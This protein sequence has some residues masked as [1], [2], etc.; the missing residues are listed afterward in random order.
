M[1]SLNSKLYYDS[2]YNELIGRGNVGA[3]GNLGG[4]GF[5]SIY[6]D[7]SLGLIETVDFAFG[8][9]IDFKVGLN[10]RND[11]H[12]ARDPQKT[13]YDDTKL[14]DFTTSIFAE[15]AQRINSWFR[16]AL[17]GSYDRNDILKAIDS[18]TKTEKVK[19]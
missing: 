2:F 15:Y 9:N 1:V 10:L 8:D 3:N 5:G 12:N 16:F 6:N 7:Y 17:N 14:N 4:S 11:N 19:L 18:N 13:T